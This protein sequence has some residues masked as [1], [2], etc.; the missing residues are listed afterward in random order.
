L[1]FHVVILKGLFAL[2]DL[3]AALPVAGVHILVLQR[4][5]LQSARL[6]VMAGLPAE[7][8]AKAGHPERSEESLLD[9]LSAFSHC[10]SRL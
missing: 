10:G 7:A 8:L 5:A 6:S 3:S 2:K 1:R 9:L 4:K